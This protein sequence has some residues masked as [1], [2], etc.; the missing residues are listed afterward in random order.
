M[1]D[2]NPTLTVN[3]LNPDYQKI[4]DKI[5]TYGIYKRYSL[6]SKPQIGYK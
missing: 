5:Q 4:K 1:A 3:R 6:D 2:I